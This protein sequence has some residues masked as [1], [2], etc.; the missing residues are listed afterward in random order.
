MWVKSDL[1][2]SSSTII[3]LLRTAPDKRFAVGQIASYPLVNVK[4]VVEVTLA[5]AKVL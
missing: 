5:A 2:C 1:S 3:G 4:D